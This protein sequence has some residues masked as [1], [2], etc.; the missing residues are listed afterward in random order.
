MVRLMI[1]E[2]DVI[3]LT[4]DLPGHHLKV[5][6]IGTVVDAHEDEYTVEFVRQDGHTIALVEVEPEMIRRINPALEILS[7]RRL[8]A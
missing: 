3:A 2:L 7:T 4:I 8:E 1:K 5:D 6:D